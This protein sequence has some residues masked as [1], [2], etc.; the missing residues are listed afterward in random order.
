MTF[1]R[2][3]LKQFLPYGIGV[4]LTAGYAIFPSAPVAAASYQSLHDFYAYP[5]GTSTYAH[6]LKASDGIMYGVANSGGFYN[7]GTI[8]SVTPS[9]VRTT[10]YS[11][12]GDLARPSSSLVEGGDGALYGATGFSDQYLGAIF[13][14]SPKTGAISTVHG[15]AYPNPLW[16]PG[17]LT[18]GADGALYG[19]AASTASGFTMSM[20]RCSIT[21]AFSVI[22]SFSVSEGY[23]LQHI[24]STPDK[25]IYGV[26]NVGGA[27]G[28]GYIYKMSLSGDTKSIYSFKKSDVYGSSPVIV[29]EDGNLWGVANRG[30]PT[31]FGGVYHISPAGAG[32]K[33][34]HAFDPNQGLSYNTSPE[35]TIGPDHRYYGSL[36][37][38]STNYRGAVYAVSAAGVFNIL[39]TTGSAP[40]GTCDDGYT[41]GPDGA[42]YGVNVSG[43][44]GAGGIVRL[45]T[46]GQ[47]KIISSFPT[48]DG[49]SV[50][51]APALA[52]DGSYYGVTPYGGH[53]NVGTLYR[54]V[55]GGKQTI[56][57]SFTLDEGVPWNVVLGTDG[58]IY[59]A[60]QQRAFKVSPAGV[61]SQLA[62]FRFDGPISAGGDGSF[63]FFEQSIAHKMDKS[64]AISQV[65]SIP[66]SVNYISGTI[67]LGSNGNLYGVCRTGG[68]F[69]HGAIV[70]AA[71]GGAFVTAYSFKGEQDGALPY[72]KLVAGPDGNLYGVT[73]SDITTNG[74]VFRYKIGT[75]TIQSLHT[76]TNAGGTPLGPVVVKADGTIVGNGGSDHIFTYTISSLGVYLESSVL[77]TLLPSLPTP[78]FDL[79]VEPNGTVAGSSTYGGVHGSGA[80]FTLP[81]L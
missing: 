33:L 52:S 73:Y 6:L 21:G 42:L 54:Q 49:S 51:S 15:F 58:S 61:Y 75:N 32:Y 70:K 27:N 7:L 36:D 40:D 41:P 66:S 48:T 39:H 60:S 76:Y 62:N 9:G 23:P 25:H 16:F 18:V 37:T 14:F 71:P 44:N 53:N 79:V 19:L 74:T 77:P 78:S 34:V 28:S 4:A 46:A 43:S 24:F 13:R 59:G 50:A 69:G 2:S 55:P 8:Y 29:G 80:I 57:H 11:F 26:S 31:G 72:D 45:T 3:R 47:Y 17:D 63:Y 22:H 65:A 56:L 12:H 35:L 68:D 64:G 5:E 20:F 81:G 10:L 38:G 67:T 1:L 30:G